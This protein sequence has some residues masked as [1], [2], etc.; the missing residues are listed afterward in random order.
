M[1]QA[2]AQTAPHA[3]PQGLP[4][5]DMFAPQQAGMGTLDVLPMPQGQLDPF[6]A[7]VTPDQ[8]LFDQQQAYG[9]QPYAQQAYGQTPQQP[10]QGDGQLGVPPQVQVPPGAPQQM[11]QQ[12]VPTPT[13]P[14]QGPPM[15]NGQ[16]YTQPQYPGEQVPQ[17]VPQAPAP[18]PQMPAGTPAPVPAPTPA[19]PQ[20]TAVPEA[21]VAPVRPVRPT[22]P[23]RPAGFDPY[24]AQTNPDS[25][26]AAYVRAHYDFME[27][28][29]QYQTAMATYEQQLGQYQREHAAYDQAVLASLAQQAQTGYGMSADEAQA[30]LTWTRSEGIDDMGAWI[31]AFRSTRQPQQPQAPAPFQPNGP[32]GSYALGQV[33]GPPVQVAQDPFGTQ[34]QQA[35]QQAPAFPP[36]IGTLPGQTTSQAVNE[37]V[38]MMQQ[39]MAANQG[40]DPLQPM[41]GAPVFQM[42]PG[43]RAP[44]QFGP[45]FTPGFPGSRF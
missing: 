24:E 18:A 11:P 38:L 45:Q 40:F 29:G 6:Q 33:A 30:F 26:S 22:A 10:F 5:T 23:E 13:Y 39:M 2:P 41:P 17:Q 28:I 44:A 16:P 21:P 25:E 42:T 35:F 8:Y 9:Q 1:P 19:A 36:A 15:P 4:P 3:V 7:P 14:P 27:Q 12:A 37:E 43:G 31:A 20:Q 34:R 32:A